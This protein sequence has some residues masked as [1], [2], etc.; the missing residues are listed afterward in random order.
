MLFPTISP[1]THQL[2]DSFKTSANNIG[3]LYFT[4]NLLD[5]VCIFTTQAHVGGSGFSPGGQRATE[6]GSWWI[7]Q[8]GVPG[9][10]CHF[11]HL[12]PDND[13]AVL[14]NQIRPRNSG[15]HCQLTQ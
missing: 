10:Q 6:T 15:L 11:P 3:F 8:V 13:L 7:L 9:E 14:N 5:S 1:T 2:Y 12:R 4:I